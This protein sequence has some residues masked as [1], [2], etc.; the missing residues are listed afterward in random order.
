[1]IDKDLISKYF[2]GECTEDELLVI[3]R[4]MND[5]DWA[6]EELDKMWRTNDTQTQSLEREKLRNLVIIRQRSNYK[7]TEGRYKVWDNYYLRVAAILLLAFSLP[8]LLLDSDNSKVIKDEAPGLVTKSNPAGRKSTYYLPDGSV[9]KLNASSEISFREVFEGNSREVF[10]TGE[11]FFDV[12]ENPDKPFLVH[13]GSIT[14]KALGTSFNVQAFGD[15]EQIEV[16]LASGKVE[17]SSSGSTLTTLLPGE[18]VIYQNRDKSHRKKIADLEK[19]L[20]WK[21]NR[22][23]FEKASAEEILTYLERWYGVKFVADPVVVSKP[24]RFSGTYKNESLENILLS[25]SYVKS[26]DFTIEDK[27]VYLTP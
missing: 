24:W 15:D 19:A 20:A 25:L 10:L 12:A 22:I 2:S 5:E 13:S 3:R 26:F 18:G 17:V 21:D 9:V 4:Y 8:L 27:T 6:M 1:M 23:V 11:A 7:R 16:V 14:T